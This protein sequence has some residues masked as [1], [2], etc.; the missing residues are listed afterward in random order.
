MVTPGAQDRMRGDDVGRRDWMQPI[1]DLYGGP[2]GAERGG[3]EVD[4]RRK[5]P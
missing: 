1:D 4:P 3:L 5:P 2:T